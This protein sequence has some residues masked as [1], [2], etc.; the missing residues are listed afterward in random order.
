[1]TL[2]TLDMTLSQD[3]ATAIAVARQ[4]GI[5]AIIEAIDRFVPL[6]NVQ[7]NGTLFSLLFSR[8]TFRDGSSSSSC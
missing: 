4:G 5:P 7:V 1:M 3:A 6:E 2:S 8:I